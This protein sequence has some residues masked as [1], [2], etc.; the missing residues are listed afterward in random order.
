[1]DSGEGS[2]VIW[3]LDLKTLTSTNINQSAPNFVKIYMTIRSQMSSILGLIGPEG[4]ELSALEWQKLLCLPFYTLA[5]I[6][7]YRPISTILCQNINNYNIFDG[8]NYWSYCSRTTERRAYSRCFVCSSVC[9][10]IRL[11]PFLHNP[12]PNWIKLHIWTT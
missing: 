9:P 1:M 11:S 12:G 2:K 8:F 4:Q 10:S 6:Y 5:S 3:S 7:M